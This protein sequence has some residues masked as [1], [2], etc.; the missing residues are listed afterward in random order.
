MKG[1]STRTPETFTF[2]F[3][4]RRFPVWFRPEES[5]RQAAVVSYMHA[6]QLALARVWAKAGCSRHFCTYRF[7]SYDDPAAIPGPV[8]DCGWIDPSGNDPGCRLPQGFV[9]RAGRQIPILQAAFDRAPEEA[10]PIGRSPLPSPRFSGGTGTRD[11]P[12]RISS[13]EELLLLSHLS[14]H[15]VCTGIDPTLSEEVGGDFPEWSRGKHFRLTRDIVWN[16]PAGDPADRVPFPMI[17]NRNGDYGRAT[18]FAGTLDGA[19]H[20]TLS[21]C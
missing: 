7:T 11:D 15:R 8:S 6:H 20:F 9:F 12:Y 1:S 5:T 16:D 4:E 18:R 3:A 10:Q 14:N 2:D 13:A 19:G 17:C 21:L